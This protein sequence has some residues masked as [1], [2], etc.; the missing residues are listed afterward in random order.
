MFKKLGKY[1]RRIFEI[2][3]V[4]TKYDYASR[5]YDFFNAFCIIVNLAVSM[6]YT[7][8][9]YRAQYG[10]LLLTLEEL[11]VA[12]FLMDYIL[13]IWTAG[14]LYPDLPVWRATLKYM[15]SF[16]GIVDLL[17]FL[18]QYLPIFF[19]SGA[20]AFRM[21]RI[22]RI[23]RLFRINAYYDALNVITKVIV[24][25]KQQ[26]FS[27]VFIILMLMFASSLCMYSLEHQAQPDVFS[28]AFSGI[29]WAASTLLTVG[30]GDIYPITTLGKMFGIFI[31]FLGVGIVAIPTGIISAGFV[32]QYSR[33]KRMAE[34]GPQSAINFIK[35]H[36][37]DRD[38]WID[39][40]ISQLHLPD[41]V[42]VAVVK[43]GDRILVPR[44]NMILRSDDIMVLGAESYQDD[45]EHIKLKEFLLQKNH[46]WIGKTIRSLEISRHSIIVLIRRNR[47]VM[48]PNGNMI[49]RE[50]DT[51]ILYT[52]SYLGGDGDIEI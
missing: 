19:P 1:K 44:G 22:I 27:S 43:R 30:Y 2:I 13:R 21:F 33:I 36:L 18:P 46:P 39:H 35:I 40:T 45:K 5:I 25:K 37:T 12:L 48:I 42:I 24:G 7:F 14:Y 38:P 52:Q 49:L 47:K 16:T 8:E 10:T 20:I 9:E 51:V 23:F 50:N 26:L 31:A 41:S 11:T 4:G 15:F 29:W 6:L 32:D 34:Y 3:E 17:S 28:N